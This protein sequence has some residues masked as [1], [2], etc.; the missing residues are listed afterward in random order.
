[1]K[2]KNLL[3]VFM[4]LSSAQL[5]S[6][7]DKSPNSKLISK[8]EEEKNYVEALRLVNLD[9]DKYPDHDWNYL[10]RSS[11]Y[12]AMGKIEDAYLSAEKAMILNN[13]NPATYINMGNI[14]LYAGDADNAVKLFTSAMD[15]TPKDS[16]D[17]LNSC[18]LNRAAAYAQVRKYQE[19][20][21]DLHLVYLRDSSNVG[22]INNMAA[23]MDDLG[24]PEEGI[25]LLKKLI[26]IDPSFTGTYVNLGFKYNQMEQYEKGLTYLDKAILM[27]PDDGIAYN[28]RAYSKYKLGRNAEALDDVNKSLELYPGNSYAYKNRALIYV[29]LKRMNMACAD[30]SKALEMGFSK[31]YGDEV[32][33]LQKQHC[34]N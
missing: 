19:A 16:T 22:V 20:Y 34:P 4:L 14:F 32:E 1:M 23:M 12:I 30:I 6:Q 31:M 17:I 28:N 26:E 25:R 8:A 5:F 10:T 15:I 18:L 13:K 3:L 11:I 9:I 27:K 21:N 2:F 29:A 7:K 24:R 33:K